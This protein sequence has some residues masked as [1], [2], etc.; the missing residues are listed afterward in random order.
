MYKAFLSCP[1]ASLCNKGLIGSL[2]ME[3]KAHFVGGSQDAII[4]ETDLNV[5][6]VQPPG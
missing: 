2:E 6:Y 3:N 1:A 5:Q 4:R